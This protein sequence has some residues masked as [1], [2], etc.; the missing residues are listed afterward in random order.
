M[1][2]GGRIKQSNYKNFEIVETKFNG[3]VEG[4]SSWYDLDMTTIIDNSNERLHYSKINADQA[5]GDTPPTNGAEIIYRAPAQ[6]ELHNL[7]PEAF[8]ILGKNITS[9]GVAYANGGINI[10]FAGTPLNDISEVQLLVNNEKVER[11]EY[12]NLYS[13]IKYIFE[14]N[15]TKQDKAFF[16]PENGSAPHTFNANTTTLVAEE[17]NKSIDLKLKHGNGVKNALKHYNYPIYLKDL[18]PFVEQHP[19]IIPGSEIQVRIKLLRNDNISLFRGTGVLDGVTNINKLVLWMPRV[20]PSSAM[21][22]RI[23]SKLAKEQN[24]DVAWEGVD[25]VNTTEFN[26]ARTVNWRVH[27][28]ATRVQRVVFFVRDNEQLASQEE[29]AYLTSNK[30]KPVSAYILYNGERLP[31]LDLERDNNGD[32]VRMYKEYLRCARKG[33]TSIDSVPL[34]YEQFVNGYTLL[35]FDLS[36]I[37]EDVMSFNTR[38]HIDF[39]A[40]FAADPAVNLDITAFIWYDKWATVRYGSGSMRITDARP[41]Q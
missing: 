20:K 3:V 31:Q 16:R 37:N 25:I 32:Y 22:E 14:R 13:L 6:H 21:N 1:S 30:A 19:V 12:A 33:P 7:L 27:N 35:C 36:Q 8:F 23:L 15:N 34:S 26:S 28:D 18:F 2:K 10:T 24:V 11:I 4:M 38:A 29:N 41:F 39:V 40:K 9:S 17:F 5:T